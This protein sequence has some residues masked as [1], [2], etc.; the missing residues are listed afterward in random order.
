MASRN[1]VAPITAT[2]AAAVVT[3]ESVVDSDESADE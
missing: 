3:D 1:I 2:S